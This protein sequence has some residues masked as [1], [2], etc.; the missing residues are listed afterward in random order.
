MSI[1]L[2]WVAAAKA[3][4]EIS[5]V[6]CWLGK[7]ANLTSAV[8]RDLLKDEEIAGQATLQ[9]PAAIDFLLLTHGHGCKEFKGLWC[10]NLTSYSESIH[11]HI[12][13]IQDLVNK[14]KVKKNPE[15]FEDLSDI[16]I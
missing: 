16:G 13:R 9:N 10:F 14:L 12:Q 7:P 6:E 11:S 8:L 4:G 15:W 2:P 1:F 5:H 3:L